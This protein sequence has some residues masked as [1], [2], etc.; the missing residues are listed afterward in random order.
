M[1]RES[2]HEV[3]LPFQKINSKINGFDFKDFLLPNSKA[4]SCRDNVPTNALNLFLSVCPQKAV[5]SVHL[6][7]RNISCG[8]SFEHFVGN[9][10]QL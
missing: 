3:N 6:W 9:R 10:R 8:K 4:L 7:A 1:Q 2:K 5:L